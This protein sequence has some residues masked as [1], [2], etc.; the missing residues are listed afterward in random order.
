MSLFYSSHERSERQQRDNLVDSA[1]GAAS[2]A[3]LHF[4][5]KQAYSVT[6]VRNLLASV[7]VVSKEIKE[8][9]EVVNL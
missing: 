2:I 6:E 3:I 9:K 1:L 8:I 7:T 5:I 4:P